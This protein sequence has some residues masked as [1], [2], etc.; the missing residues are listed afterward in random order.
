MP[1]SGD[2]PFCP[3]LTLSVAG[4][5][6]SVASATTSVD[7]WDNANIGKSGWFDPY[8][9]CNESD[10]G[11][12]L[13]YDCC[14]TVYPVACWK[15]QCMMWNDTI[16]WC[17]LT[18]TPPS[19][20]K[21]AYASILTAEYL[22]NQDLDGNGKVYGYDFHI[23]GGYEWEKVFHRMTTP[24]DFQQDSSG[25][26]G[27]GDSDDGNVIWDKSANPFANDGQVVWDDEY[28]PTFEF[29]PKPIFLYRDPQTG[30]MHDHPGGRLSSKPLALKGIPNRGRG[31]TWE[32]FLASMD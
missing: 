14:T 7:C 19:K 26:S 6:G 17:G 18:V 32:A 16:E 20:F 4:G 10:I 8:A 1:K 12:G 27:G 13:T 23:T 2:L 29:E 22:C 9:G 5:T 25:G 31:M 21:V 30:E 28:S 15:S 11:C 24:S 3:Y